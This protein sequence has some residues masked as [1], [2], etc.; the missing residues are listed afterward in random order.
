MSE[1][2]SI[3]NGLDIVTD[4]YSFT[5]KNKEYTITVMPLAYAKEYMDE[6]MPLYTTENDNYST[7]LYNFATIPI[8]GNKVDMTAKLEK[9]IPR[10]LKYQG[11]PCTL[12]MLMSHEWD[13]VDLG[14]FLKK[15]VGVSG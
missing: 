8:E 7:A 9:W 15:A 10:L 3:T 12:E 14:R 11:K 5:A 13:I 1:K 4:L 2:K 6:D